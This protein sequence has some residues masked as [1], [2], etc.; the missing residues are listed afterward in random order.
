SKSWNKSLDFY[1]LGG[2]SLAAVRVCT[3]LAETLSSEGSDMKNGGSWSKVEDKH[4][5]ASPLVG[6]Q[7]GRHLQD[8]VFAVANLLSRPRLKDYA[9][10]LAAHVGDFESRLNIF[11]GA[12]TS[13]KPKAESTAGSGSTFKKPETRKA[14]DASIQKPFTSPGADDAGPRPASLRL[15]ERLIKKVRMGPHDLAQ[16]LLRYLLRKTALQDDTTSS[17]IKKDRE[18]YNQYRKILLRLAIGRGQI[19][20]ARTIHEAS[21]VLDDRSTS[22]RTSPQKPLV[23]TSDFLRRLL[24]LTLQRNPGSL[25]ML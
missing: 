8:T 23:D 14:S 18:E 21:S 7:E 19:A 4:E 16:N 5:R 15:A 10:F 12:A 24:I 6:V 3:K 1:D 11:N 13:G 25:E 22:I 20:F 9:A 2:D 17:D